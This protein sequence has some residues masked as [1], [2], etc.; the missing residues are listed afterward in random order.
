ML[1]SDVTE[2]TLILW[3]PLY[4]HTL[5]PK[6]PFSLSHMQSEGDD[7]S[8]ILVVFVS[9]QDKQSPELEYVPTEQTHSLDDDEPCSTVVFPLLQSVQLAPS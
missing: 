1:S 3:Q 4:E 6:Y 8:A 7:I 5:S 9:P 2:I